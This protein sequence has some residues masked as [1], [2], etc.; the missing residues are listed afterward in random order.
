[1]P[2][3]PIH[4]PGL[5]T[6][7][8]ST[9]PPLPATAQPG[10]QPLPSGTM[11]AGV[12]PVAQTA[13]PAAPIP[14]LPQAGAPVLPPAPQV[15]PA[16]LA[17]F[18]AQQQLQH[19][20][21]PAA[22]PQAQPAPQ[23]QPQFATGGPI[24]PTAIPGLAPASIP[25]LAP[26]AQPQAQPAQSAATAPAQPAAN[27]N[28]PAAGEPDGISDGNGKE[29]PEGKPLAEMTDAEQAKYY[30]W[31]S[32]QWESR[33]KGRSDYDQLKEKA[34][35]F[36]QLSA[37]NATEVEQRI[38][39]ARSEGFN[40][41]AQAAA[42]VLVDAHVRA[43]LQSR[44]QPH[45]VEALAG[46]L[47]HQHFLSADGRTVD[48]AKVSAFVDTVAPAPASPADPAVPAATAP[49]APAVPGALPT[50]VPNPLQSGQPA[51]GLPRPDLG[52]GAQTAA[53]L[54]KLAL[55]RQI[56]QQHLAGNF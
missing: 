32:R 8:G 23:A 46:N 45:Q 39:A 26:A 52:Q 51:T 29:Y 37:A 54:D 18:L 35:Q 10:G 41:A 27:A 17:Q 5:V 3:A 42:V 50:G 7:T 44:L 43:G 6:A 33:A 13:Q 11:T 15:D 4:I 12:L 9:Q 49:A 31:Y 56:A 24:L 34:A 36:D 55:G 53:P 38:A 19:Q 2:D 21:A 47:N 48:A 14:A 30:K 1:M 22:Q 40:Q 20:T 16:A 28:P 25:G